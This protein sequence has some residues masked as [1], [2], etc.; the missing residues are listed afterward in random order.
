M[1]HIK[2]TSGVRIDGIIAK[3]PQ[4]RKSFQSQTFAAA[5]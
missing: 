5:L 2:D 1:R 4:L 3:S